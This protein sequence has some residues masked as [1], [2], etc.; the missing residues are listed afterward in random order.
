MRLQ[1][2]EKKFNLSALL[3]GHGMR[4]NYESHRAKNVQSVEKSQGANSISAHIRG[5]TRDKTARA[6]GQ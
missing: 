3:G 1:E 5:Q 2:E 4:Q 6:I